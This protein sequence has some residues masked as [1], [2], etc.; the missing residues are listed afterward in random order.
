[1]RI[2]I[3]NDAGVARG[4]ATGLALLSARL[5]AAQG[6]DV[7]YLCG[8]TGDDGTLAG[9]GV[10]VLPMGGAGLLKRSRASALRDGLYDAA[11]RDKVA[12]AIRDIDT[13]Q[14]VYHLHGWAQ[15]LSP[16]IFDAL[17]PVAARTYVHAH[18]F[19]LA[20]P[21][22]S[23]F[24]FK[25]GQTCGRRPLSAACLT[26]NCDRRSYPQ[27][28]WRA[29]RQAHIRKGAH[30]RSWAGILNLH[31]GMTEGLIRGGVD[32]AT[33]ITVRNPAE[34]ITTTRVEAETNRGLV[35]IGRTYTG[36]GAGLLCRA[37]R[38]A[39][40][41]LR[42]VGAVDDRPDLVAAHPEVDFTGWV[43]RSEIAASISDR[44]ILVMPSRFPEP[45]GLV[46]PEGALSGLPVA[47]SDVALLAGDVEAAGVG[48]AVDV[49]SP[50]TLA[51]GL[52]ALHDRPD[53]EIRAMSLR[54]FAGA[55]GV[56]Q[57]P[58]AWAE[59]L[60]DLYRAAV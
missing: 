5:F 26:T 29:L 2:V 56:T 9:L 3:I 40:L 10:T 14:T 32:P 46:A 1:M 38:I 34:R 60:L 6:H 45:F 54:G 16:S 43:D 49:T 57:T 18:D 41:P 7:T 4:G 48:L 59:Q 58:E 8:D 23:Y 44:R 13:A 51:D 17:A 21:N 19:F 11:M 53:D 24:D 42:I 28:L 25:A 47:V 37:A 30:G 35:F 50:E 52:R 31:P 15:I 36:K 12:A 55:E 33:L 20:C 22:G 39:G 27:K